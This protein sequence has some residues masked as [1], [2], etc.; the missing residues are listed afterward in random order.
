MVAER[1]TRAFWPFW[2]V[3]FAALAPLMM[4]WQDSLPVEL[5]WGFV[6]VAATGLVVTLVLG[7]RRMTWPTRVEAMARVDSRLPG[8]PLAALADAQAIGATDPASRAVWDAH[9]QRMAE[10]SRTARAVEPDLRVSRND[11]Y[12][13]RYI[14]LLFF[15]A[16]LLFGSVLR[17]GSVAEMTPG[18]GQVL[19]TG[20][21]WEGWVEPP[22]YT[23]RPALYLAD[24]P[25]GPLRV[26]EGS[27]ITLRLYGE[28]GALT[29][30]ETV[31]G[32]T[33]EEIG[34]ASDLE[35]TFTVTRDGRLAING[36]GGAEWEVTTIADQPPEVD[37]SGPVEADAQG[38][39]T[40]PFRAADDYAVTSGRAVIELNLAA[41]ERDHGLI[42]DPD[43]RDPIVVDLPMPFTGDRAEFEEALID[44]FSR[45]PFA[46]M[47]VTLTLEVSDAAG[48]TGQNHPVEMTLPGRRFFQ[49]IARA[50]IEQRRD[51]LW[52]KGNAQRVVDVL[53]AVSHRPDGFFPN[54]TTYLRLDFTLRELDRYAEEGLEDE[55][56]AEIAQALWDLAIQLEDGT[57][58]D[59]RER[60][61]RAQERLAEAMR[62]GASEEEIAELMQ[63]LREATDDYMR[64]L[65]ENAEPRDGD[66]T[67]ERDT[68]E[69]TFEFSMNELQELMDEIQRLMEEGRM[70]EAEALMEQLNQ[71]LENMVVELDP[72]AQGGN[73]PGQQSMED[74]GQTL[75]DQQGLND[76]AFRDLQEQFNPGQQGQQQPGQQGQGQQQGQQ[77][78][79]QG[80][81]GQNQGQQQGQGMGQGDNTEGQ[82]GGNGEGGDQEGQTPGQSLADRQQ[83]LRDE[84]NRQRGNL[85]NLGGEAAEETR[86]SLDRAGE[87]M[88]RAEDAL[89]DGDLP[90]AIDQQ[91]EAMSALREG[92]RNLGEALAENR[93]EQEPGQGQ[94]AG[95]GQAGVE[96]M[97]RDPLGRQLGENGQFSTDQ[98]M[99]PDVQERAQ[100]LLDEL[101]RRSSDQ[102]RPELELDYLRRLL[103]RF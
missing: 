69:E 22:A 98:N 87:A 30:D 21:V 83:A 42:P 66:G 92:L 51:L 1:V 78:G 93:Q 54:E 89:R 81:Q 62:N 94:Q 40:Q 103:E 95:E 5:V 58:A 76:E 100:E 74:L 97:R 77:P 86:R 44:D 26:P 46:N 28:V 50:V 75:R 63:E 43:P 60:L 10:R 4:G 9:K 49:P 38:Q 79:Q 82:T 31:S 3:L 52:S 90:G 96:P 47:P 59:A 48:Q 56:Q 16:A 85:P 14:A 13:L 73:G 33:G 39:M 8:R 36:E 99:M 80:Q 24:I 37:V 19:A 27:T 61:R 68:G 70:A 12:G 72:N 57:L 65:A 17:V 23:G 6:V 15:V 84:L 32:R 55:Q 20:P 18:G 25:P 29:V 7:I 64:M 102:E 53:R 11:P 71:L 35:Q 88:D 67:D 101:R 45:H 41:V 34:A 91:A 2:T